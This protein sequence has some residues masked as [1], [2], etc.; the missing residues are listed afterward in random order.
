MLAL[1]QHFDMLY[2]PTMCHPNEIYKI[3]RI[4][5]EFG[6]ADSATETVR[7]VPYWENKLFVCKDRKDK[8]I[9]I[10]YYEKTTAGSSLRKYM[11][12]VSAV[13][14]NDAQFKVSMPSKL[15]NPQLLEMQSKNA[16]EIKDGQFDY[17]L[18]AYDFA[19]FNLTGDWK[20]K[21]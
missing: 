16:V 9:K 5:N 6:M 21:E 4:R 14:F 19:I 7:F 20:T 13:Q 2:F 17:N 8:D 10:S 3:Y 18:I 1:T 12:I 11:L 15:G